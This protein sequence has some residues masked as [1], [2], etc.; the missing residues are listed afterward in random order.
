MRLT[1]QRRLLH[2]VTDTVLCTCTHV[3]RYCDEVLKPTN[4]RQTDINSNI[5]S[6]G[7]TISYLNVLL[8]D[9]TRYPHSL[10]LPALCAAAVTTAA[11][12]HC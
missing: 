2:Y 1:C 7:P 6:R 3:S 8:D 10:D 5:S 4:K 9:I 12:A 11:A